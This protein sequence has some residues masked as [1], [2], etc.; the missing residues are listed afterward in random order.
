MGDRLPC[1]EAK[2]RAWLINYITSVL[3]LPGEGVPTDQTFDSY[4]FDS[5]EAVVMA[6]VMEE[7]FG[8]QVDPIQLFEHPSIDAFAKHWSCGTD[9]ASSSDADASASRTMHG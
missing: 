1:D 7:E 2:L 8:V 4:G 5:I 6:G 9:A 3:N